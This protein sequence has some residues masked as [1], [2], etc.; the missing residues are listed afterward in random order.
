[1]W[2]GMIAFCEVTWQRKIIFIYSAR[3]IYGLSN[4]KFKKSYEIRIAYALDKTG[5]GAGVGVGDRLI[6]PGTGRQLITCLV[7][8]ELAS[9]TD[10]SRRGTINAFESLPRVHT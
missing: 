10:M 4:Q 2:N 9:T 8:H 5:R 7:P 3:P 1:M 6:K